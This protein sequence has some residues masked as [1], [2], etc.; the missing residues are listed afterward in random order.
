MRALGRVL[1]WAA[2]V[3]NSA[4][5]TSARPNEFGSLEG[6]VTDPLGA[7]VP[8]VA[9][10][11]HNL[12]TDTVLSA[13]TTARGLFWFPEVPVGAYELT[14]VK[15]GFATWIQEGIIVAVGAHVSLQVE[16]TIATTE[17]STTVRA[18]RP[19]LETTRSDASTMMDEHAVAGLPLNG[20]NFL[21]L[22]VLTP[23]AVA[24]PHGS[25]SFMGQRKMY[26]VTVDGA[27]NNDTFFSDPMGLGDHP[28]YS[29]DAIGE[30]RVNTA[31]YSAELGHSGT[32]VVTVV[33]K[34][35]TN[36]F[37]GGAFAYYRDQSLNA[38]DLINEIAGQ[39]KS[40]YNFKQFGGTLGGPV[41]RNRLFFFG[42]YEGQ[43]STTEN[44][45]DL[46]LPAGFQLSP[47]PLVR[48]FQQR[49]IDYL[50]V[51]DSS[52]IRTGDQDL[53]FLKGDWTVASR[54]LLTLRVNRQP[55][56]A[57]GREGPGGPEVS[58]EHTGTTILD[59]D[60]IGGAL[61]S[62]LSPSW[63]NVAR[64]T[65]VGSRLLGLTNSANAEANVFEA[66]Q[67]VLTIG[68]IPANPRDISLRRLEWSDTASHVTGR[69]LIQAGAN[70]QH[71]NMTFL[72]A[73]NFSGS[74]RFG[75]L[76]SF[77]RSLAGTPLPL[78]G[79]RYIQAFSGE[80]TPGATTHPDRTD[81]SAFLQDEWRV[82]AQLTLNLG[83]RDDVEA[84]AQ[85]P[86][87]NP[88]LSL[89]AAGLDTSF[90]PTTG[91]HFAPRLG[92]AWIPRARV[93]VRGGYGMFYGR[94]PSQMSSRAHFQ[95]GITVATRTFLGGTPTAGS[96]PAYPNNLCG[97]P[98]SAGVPPSCAAPVAGSGPPI[99]MMFDASYRLPFV[100]Q[101]SAGVDLALN[102]HTLI[103]LSYVFAH[104][105]H[106]PRVRDVNL[107]IAIPDTIAVAGTDMTLPYLRFTGPRP[108][109]DFDRVFVFESQASSS[110]QD[111]VLQLVRRFAKGVQF[112]ASYELSGVVDD[113]SDFTAINPPSSDA[114][115]L[116]DA[117]HPE[118]DHSRGNTDVRHRVLVS[119]LV[120]VHPS[121]QF[122]KTVQM[123]LDH[124][125]LSG[126]FTA[127]S[128]QPYSGLLNFDLNNDGNAAA[129]RTPGTIR[130]GFR[131]PALVALDLRVMRAIPLGN[132]HGHLEVSWDA[133]NL[134]NRS[135]IIAVQ[136]Q[137]F[138][139]SRD[140]SVCGPGV[141]QCLVSNDRG[142]GA[143][144]VP[145]AT[146]GPRI[147]QLG[148]RYVF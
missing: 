27:D 135:N 63:V 84:L 74:Y 89:A 91:H 141:P 99:L 54:H 48:G 4:A 92:V 143:F 95:N 106:L 8:D 47:D 36:I 133:F 64:M 81:F 42:D 26:S 10:D 148:V 73:V 19:L 53:F 105:V 55:F 61:T 107:G 72:S 31:S 59:C 121:D 139:V 147:M 58:S 93:V 22:V 122:P 126:I 136:K 44:V 6:L 38:I 117:T 77:G 20:R 60:T 29:L 33:T 70:L 17:T 25:V 52:W 75:S 24:D 82:A 134:F 85:P 125:T 41:L 71:D 12:A 146:A 15:R 66:G 129:D 114:Q 13:K 116:A 109:P 96:I 120:E 23:G 111:L 83:L 57:E 34:S 124:W 138:I 51:R 90:G 30:F 102:E 2:L 88:S 103:S 94:T 49:A 145:T 69:H 43:R 5:A 21:D 68:R 115:L 9:I 131:L 56:N 11:I 119:G 3:L 39:P 14:A 87:R 127:Q 97:P 79:E 100:H 110:Y 86:V 101:A 108:M 113:N 1:V 37:R 32:G 140:S 104:G 128:G 62:T 28:L 130:N 76:E 123:V 46:N 35:G 45:V 98:T 80:G 142:S 65:Y 78:A 118:S 137:Q 50:E 67:L 112:Q 40:P 132:R 18:V 16:L 144:G 7:V